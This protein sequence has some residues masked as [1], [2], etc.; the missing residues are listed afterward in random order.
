M[1]ITLFIME[2]HGIVFVLISVGIL[3]PG[4]ATITYH[5]PACNTKRRGVQLLSGRL[6]DFRSG[7][8]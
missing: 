2:N 5:R 1:E 7:D 3:L 4:N 8:H 6:L